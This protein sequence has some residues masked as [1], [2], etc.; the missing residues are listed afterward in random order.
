MSDSNREN[1]I[2][3]T[4]FAQRSLILLL[5]NYEIKWMTGLL[6][7]Y[8]DILTVGDF[9][10]AAKMLNNI[11]CDLLIIDSMTL[12]DQTLSAIKEFKR[13]FP[14]RPVGVLW[15]NLDDSVD[16]LL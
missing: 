14:H 15:D 11:R 12:K 10:Q 13:N 9:Q 3:T 2:K 5:T 7:S 6:E 4:T 1:R 16:D 8:C